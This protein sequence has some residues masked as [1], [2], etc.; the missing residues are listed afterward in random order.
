[1]RTR[2]GWGTAVTRGGAPAPLHMDQLD[3][4][5]AWRGGCSGTTLVPMSDATPV[6]AAVEP[7]LAKLATRLP[8]AGDL[9]YELKLGR[10]PRHRLFA[11]QTMCTNT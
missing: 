3:P 9:L 1:M 8:T 10:L 4:I 7:M 6:G 5:A 11:L 2:A